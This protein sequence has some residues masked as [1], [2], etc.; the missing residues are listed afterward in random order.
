MCIHCK[1]TML[2]LKKKKKEIKNPAEGKRER[3]REM[4]PHTDPPA[5]P[6]S[7]H[8]GE[9]RKLGV[10]YTVLSEWWQ[11]SKKG[12][13]ALVALSNAGSALPLSPHP[14]LLK[15]LG[16]EKRFSSSNDR[17]TARCGA[18]VSFSFGVSMRLTRE[19]GGRLH[20]I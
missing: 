4:D 19:S 15:T 11:L 16:T 17:N 18:S 1:L 10:C 20:W 14:L 6:T 2:Q 3:E 13:D 5:R 8:C 12:C 9:R 7:L